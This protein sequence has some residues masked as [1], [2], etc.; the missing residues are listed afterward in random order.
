MSDMLTPEEAGDFAGVDVQNI[1]Q[2]LAQGKAYSVKT[3]SGQ[4]RV[5]KNSLC[6]NRWVSAPA[7]RS[8]K[9]KL[10][11]SYGE[12][13]LTKIN[14]RHRFGDCHDTFWNAPKLRMA[15]SVL[16]LYQDKEHHN[17]L[18]KRSIRWSVR[19]QWNW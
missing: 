13:Q 3:F 11:E 17:W 9:S 7:L 8:G 4:N 6:I 16:G 1:Y 5:C 2:R 19:E 15:E 12:K 18:A 14:C 10:K